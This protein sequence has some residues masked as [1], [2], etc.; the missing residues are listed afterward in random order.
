MKRI[1]IISVLSLII[2]QQ[3]SYTEKKKETYQVNMMF[4]ELLS[5]VTDLDQRKVEKSP[6]SVASHE[7]DIYRFLQRFVV[8]IGAPVTV[9]WSKRITGCFVCMYRPNNQLLAQTCPLGIRHGSDIERKPLGLLC[10]D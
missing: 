7:V 8:W 2:S 3:Q 4:S 1:V 10:G 9:T 5:N 6:K